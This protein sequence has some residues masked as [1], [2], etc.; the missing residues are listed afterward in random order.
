MAVRLQRARKRN[1]GGFV[2]QKVLPLEFH[3]VGRNGNH[4]RHPVQQV[5]DGV[6]DEKVTPVRQ[7][8]GADARFRV[9]NV[10]E[11]GR[12]PTPAAVLAQGHAQ[13]HFVRLVPVKQ[14]YRA[15]VRLIP[16][17]FAVRKPPGIH[18][19]RAVVGN[20]DNL[21]LLQRTFTGP[22]KDNWNSP[23][24]PR[25][26]QPAFPRQSRRFEPVTV[27]GDKPLRPALAVRGDAETDATADFGL[28]AGAHARPAGRPAPRFR[29]HERDETVSVAHN[30][31]GIAPHSA[32]DVARRHTGRPRPA[33]QILA[34][35]NQRLLAWRLFVDSAVREHVPVG[36]PPSADPRLMIVGAERRRTRC[37][38]RSPDRRLVEPGRPFF[39][40]GPG[41]TRFPELR[42]DQIVPNSLPEVR[43]EHRDSGFRVNIRCGHEMSPDFGSGE[44][45]SAAGQS[46]TLTTTSISSTVISPDLPRFFATS[47]I[48]S[49]L[50]P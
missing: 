30:S 1:G 15:I 11:H 31:A 14:E 3:A 37:H 48:P 32:G 5:G 20:L 12:G 23:P 25:A 28:I 9:G 8:A 29:L 17:R 50:S 7:A 46:T 42:R 4:Q 21:R 6:V 22:Q 13:P 38:P 36:P 2:D 33:G 34:A 40:V 27:F 47:P 10:R 45:R 43:R 19:S 49:V 35:R 18:P 16:R 44:T 24:R 41:A 39:S 26:Q